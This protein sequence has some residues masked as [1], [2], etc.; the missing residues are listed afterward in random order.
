MKM[1][2]SARASSSVAILLMFI[3]RVPRAPLDTSTARM[4]YFVPA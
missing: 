2:A 1:I 3:L 4:V